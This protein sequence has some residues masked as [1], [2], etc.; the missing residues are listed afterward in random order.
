MKFSQAAT[1][2][3]EGFP[4]FQGLNPSP[5]SGCEDG[6]VVSSQKSEDRHVLTWL[7]APENFTE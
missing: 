3:C 2:G 7:S 6:D 5:Y 1:S 4:M